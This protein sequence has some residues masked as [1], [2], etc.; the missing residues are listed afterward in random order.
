MKENGETRPRPRIRRLT[1]TVVKVVAVVAGVA[2]VLAP[3]QSFYGLVLFGGSIV[4]LLLCLTLYLLLGG[5]E[6]AGYWPDRPEDRN[7]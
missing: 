1:L 3:V 6:K 7:L 2:F 5:D 4:V